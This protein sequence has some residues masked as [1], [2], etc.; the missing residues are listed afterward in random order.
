MG[1]LDRLVSAT[2]RTPPLIVDGAMAVGIFALNVFG[3]AG[4]PAPPALVLLAVASIGVVLRRQNLALGCLL[5][6]AAQVGGLYVDVGFDPL[7][8]MVLLYTVAEF[9]GLGASIVA[10][11]V[12]CAMPSFGLY[13]CCIADDPRA[14]NLLGPL[15]SFVRELALEGEFHESIYPYLVMVWLAGRS[16]AR[17]RTIAWRLERQAAHVRAERER[18]AKAAVEGERS[19]IADDLRALVVQGVDRMSA[20]TRKARDRLRIDQG[21]T[22]EAIGAI[23]S[24]GRA[25]L[26]E[27]RRLLTVL[28]T[29]ID[30][31]A[32]A[33]AAMSDGHADLDRDIGTSL[34]PLG[35]DGRGVV[36]GTWSRAVERWVARPWVPDVLLVLALGIL[37]A[38]EPLVARWTVP[39]EPMA[40]LPLKPIALGVLF[41]RRR[42]PDAVLGAATVVLFIGL[43]LPGYPW[44]VERSMFVAV[45]AM[46]AF[47]GLWWGLSGVGAA[48]IALIPW[49]GLP[50][51]QDPHP[52]Q[53]LLFW[54]PV[55]L[56]T[57]AGGVAIYNS[58]RLNT[59]LQRQTELLRRTREERVR[60]AVAEERLRVARELHDVVA[61]ALTV[62]V[63]QA[64]AARVFA[65]K[66][67][68]RAGAALEAVEAGGREAIAELA[69]LVKELGPA[70]DVTPLPEPTDRNVAALVDQSKA[71]GVRVELLTDCGSDLA[72]AGLEL[73]VYRIVQEALTNVRRHAPGARAWVELHC[74]PDSVEMEITDSGPASQGLPALDPGTGLGLVGITERAALFGGSA[75]VGPTP[76]G[77]FR[78]RARLLR[79]A[80]HV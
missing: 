21:R 55:Y 41:F 13:H 30:A 17:R 7:P 78:V 23:E 14:W 35:R 18:L 54:T 22:A 57:V 59:E 12:A 11:I 64:G 8:V 63:I 45:F 2:R 33:D 25:T 75:E 80:V 4:V 31:T 70:H 36:R 74:S 39:L 34:A 48:V 73:A 49:P 56:F 1:R 42:F 76:E 60:L 66:D 28:R 3:G 65:A 10:L 47:G 43:R 44:T 69:G 68:P 38:I 51:V 16:Q 15:K 9:R 53:Q 37:T 40:F 71:D 5:V 24:I 77:G 27:M 67:L 61:H 26:V 72:D 46:A 58:R 50:P 62:M 19:R 6:V 20:A 29:S 79:D 52:L 32:S